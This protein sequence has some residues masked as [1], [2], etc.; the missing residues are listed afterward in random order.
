VSVLLQEDRGYV[1]LL[2]LNRP[3]VLNALN[4]DLMDALAAAL[5]AAARDAGVRCVVLTGSDQ[6]FAAGADIAEMRDKTP[7]DMLDSAQ[8]T[9]WDAIRGFPKP[10][11]G[12]V[13]GW[14]LGGG[15]ELALCCDFL[16]ASETARFGQPEVQI[17]V[18]P[19]A[20]GT[21]RLPRIIGPSRALEVILTGRRLTADEALAWGLVNYV[22]PV[23]AYLDHA[24]ALAEKV[25]QGP[26][27][28]VRLAKEAVWFG[29]QASLAE[30]LR[31]ER[32]LFALLFATEDQR[33]GMAAFLEKRPPRY[34]GR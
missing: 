22:A 23:E 2:R 21:Q 6:A 18:M 17:G 14:V 24:L 8:L 10:L 20:G 15:L 31:H 19:G 11:V 9:R 5:E 34:Q 33:E 12:A 32:R 28:A 13:S 1:R 26:P 27:V 7:Q 29:Q 4:S 16:V 3:S 25:A 30:G